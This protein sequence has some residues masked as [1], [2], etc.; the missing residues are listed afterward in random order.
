VRGIVGL[1]TYRSLLRGRGHGYA[2]AFHVTDLGVYRGLCD[3]IVIRRRGRGPSPRRR[4][5]SDFGLDTG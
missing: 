4:P 1:N 2:E 3:E 5:A